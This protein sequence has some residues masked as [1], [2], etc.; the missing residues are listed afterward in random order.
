MSQ[1][2]RRELMSNVDKAWLRMDSPTNLMIINGVLLFDEVVAFE[3]FKAVCEH[4]LAG[5]YA[6][7]RQRI[8]EAPA[9]TGRLHWEV[10][11]HFDIRSHVRRIALPAPGDTATLQTLIG[12]LMSEALDANKPLWQFYL[13]E[14]VNGGCA[15]FARFHHCIA[16]G[17]ALVN[18][19]LSLTDGQPDA[20]VPQ[21]AQG[22]AAA[23]KPFDL[24]G[25]VRSMAHKAQTVTANLLKAVV[26]EGLQTIEH[27]A[28]ALELAKVTG[29]VG[30]TGAAILAKLLVMP[31]DRPSVLKG[32]LGATKR[33]V[34]SDPLDLN[35]V[36]A[37]GRA[38]GAT[39][40]DVLVAAMAGA[41]R[42][43]LLGRGDPVDSGE[44]RAM[45]PVNLRPLHDPTDSQAHELGN[46]FSLVYLALPVSIADARARLLDVK[47]RMDILKSS[48][49][50]MLVYQIL[51]VLGM[52]PGELAERAVRMFAAK[53][54]AVLTNV[55]GPRQMLYF[56]GKPLR[57]IHVWVPQSGQIGLGISIISYAGE[58]T[59]GLVVDDAVVQN[60]E[61]IISGFHAA[62]VEL[63]HLA[64][65]T[66]NPSG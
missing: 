14:N 25:S 5:A 1:P 21:P 2:S 60:P 35:Q 9:G 11:P 42:S 23:P 64:A 50:P 3:H 53:A 13:I 15:A 18:V 37:I 54:S 6:R 43:Y 47:R 4:R 32:P 49:E 62:F 58:V 56:A 63:T 31:P 17:I 10:D 19:L 22:K 51:N 36:K 59:V 52:L 46:R 8:V 39:V 28:H 30:A 65:P 34:W 33:V 16:D 45:V 26:Y 20:P 29:L 41:L 55:P 44:L 24:F 38:T 40:N 57:G 7:F 61:A 12:T 48:P 66:P 27:P